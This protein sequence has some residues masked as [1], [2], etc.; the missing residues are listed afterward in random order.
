MSVLFAGSDASITIVII[1]DT[2][3][4]RGLDLFVVSLFVESDLRLK[5]ISFY[6][7]RT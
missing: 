7:K 4:H 2:F 3:S 1:F 5:A 6:T